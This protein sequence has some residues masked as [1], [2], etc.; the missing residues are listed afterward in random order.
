MLNQLYRTV[1]M[2]KML[3]CQ[4]K[5]NEQKIKILDDETIVR[6]TNN[7]IFEILFHKMNFV[8]VTENGNF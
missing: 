2:L 7:T 3:F 5:W 6:N 1:N 8:S 4:Q